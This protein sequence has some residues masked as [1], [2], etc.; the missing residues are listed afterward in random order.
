VASCPDLA[1]VVEQALTDVLPDCMRTVQLDC[2]E[3]LDFD[4]AAALGAFDSHQFAWDLAVDKTSMLEAYQNL[5]TWRHAFVH[6]GKK[7]ASLDEVVL[8]FPL[9]KRLVMVLDSA[10]S[11]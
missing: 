4:A 9:S 3:A 11:P 10:M 6:E 2:I 8:A 1:A 7:L 5:I